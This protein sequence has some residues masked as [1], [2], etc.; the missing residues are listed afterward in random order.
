MQ[1][2]FELDRVL[3]ERRDHTGFAALRAGEHEMQG[4]QGFPDAR[5]SGDQGGGAP[6]VAVGEHR[7]QGRDAGGHPFGG[8]TVVGLVDGVGQSGE[9]LQPAGGSR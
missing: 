4:E 2:P 8:L 1:D 5:W 9:D 3:L 7:V 6:P